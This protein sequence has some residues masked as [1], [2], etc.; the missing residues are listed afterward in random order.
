ML[1]LVIMEPCLILPGYDYD[2]FLPLYDKQNALQNLLKIYL[3][4]YWIPNFDMKV[5]KSQKFHLF[6]DI[7]VQELMRGSL[8]QIHQ[9]FPKKEFCND[10][11]S[12]F[13]E[14][15]LPLATFFSFSA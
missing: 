7:I 15:A 1:L 9:Y 6:I 14:S 13:K 5:K 10:T 8:A 11:K 12:E 2:G 4:G 3:E